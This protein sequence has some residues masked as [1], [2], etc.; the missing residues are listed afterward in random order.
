MVQNLDRDEVRGLLFVNGNFNLRS[1][2]CDPQ[3]NGRVDGGSTADRQGGNIV[4]G[5]KQQGQEERFCRFNIMMT[6]F[7][8]KDFSSSTNEEKGK[9]N[10]SLDREIVR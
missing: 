8:R 4:T 6:N 1:Y 10:D 3:R 9:G 5:W 7:R 2:L